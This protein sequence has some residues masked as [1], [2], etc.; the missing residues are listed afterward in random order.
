MNQN[1][2]K[3]DP[4]LQLNNQQSSLRVFVE[5]ETLREGY[6]TRVAAV[7]Y[8][9]ANG[10]EVAA[11]DRAVDADDE[12][13]FE[14]ALASLVVFCGNYPVWTFDEGEHALKDSCHRFAVPFPFR[15]PFVH[16]RALLSGWG[17]RR[18]AYTA[19]TL[20][21]AAGLQDDNASG[22]LHD[23]RSVARAVS[24]FENI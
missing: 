5:A 4:V 22:A 13:D 2:Y 3:I 19:A 7:R 18:S 16:V 11:F 8:D 15:R 21:M 9:V 20:Y 23:A 14:R 17:I 12:E 24:F 1:A 10:K 6:I